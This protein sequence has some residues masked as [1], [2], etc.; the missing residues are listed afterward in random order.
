MPTKCRQS[1]LRK[2]SLHRRF[3]R[4]RHIHRLHTVKGPAKAPLLEADGP[5][6]EVISTESELKSPR[7][8][9]RPLSH[10]REASAR[11]N[12]KRREP[13]DKNRTHFISKTTES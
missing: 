5:N 3:H 4:P 9:W 13:E 10:P 12:K 1:R 2:M 6:G 11:M 7:S 8:D